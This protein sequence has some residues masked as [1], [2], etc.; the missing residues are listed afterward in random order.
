[1]PNFQRARCGRSAD[2]PRD[3]MPLE[4]A[5]RELL[6]FHRLSVTQGT[7]KAST[8]LQPTARVGPK[9]PLSKTLLFMYQIAV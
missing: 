4:M 6:S 2:T 9:A 1:M 8:K 5:L 3:Y 7:G